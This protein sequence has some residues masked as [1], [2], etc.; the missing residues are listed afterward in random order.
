MD[1][2]MRAMAKKKTEGKEDL[3]FAVKLAGQKLSKYCA[4]VNATPGMLLISAQ[5][6]NP[7]WKLWS[8]R[9]WDQGMDINPED[10][11]SHT[12]LNNQAFH[13]YVGNEYCAKH[14]R[15]PVNQPDS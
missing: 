5:I 14:W 8:Y 11:T 6:L 13:K 2:V 9:K 7:F 15:V 1:G 12:T 3:F 10:E 4:E